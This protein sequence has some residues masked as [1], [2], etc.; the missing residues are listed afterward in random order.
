MTINFR[1]DPTSSLPRAFVLGL[2]ALV[3]LAPATWAGEDCASLES[4]PCMLELVESTLGRGWVGIYFENDG[5]GYVVTEV[6]P[7]GPAE[8]AGLEPG[9][10]LVAMDGVPMSRKHEK[11]LA[12]IYQHMIPGAELVYT[13]ERDGQEEKVAVTLGRLPEKILSI[14][15]GQKLIERYVQATGEEL[16]LPKPPPAPKPPKPGKQKAPRSGGR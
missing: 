8:I 1:S 10:R 13:V 3:C 2:C 12:K 5:R 7:G 4:C 9:D 16:N 6:V 15:L 11:N 14:F